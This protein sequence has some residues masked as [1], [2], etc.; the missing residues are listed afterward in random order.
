M[1]TLIHFAKSTPRSWSIALPNGIYPVVVLAGDA[2]YRDQI[3]NLQIGS[4]LVID[5]DPNGG[6][7]GGTGDFDALGRRIAK[8]VQGRTTLYL[9]AGAQTVAELELPALPPSQA[10]IDGTEADGTLANMRII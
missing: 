8:T 10:A 5:P 9:P 6:V 7:A 4:E 2:A 3:N 1:D